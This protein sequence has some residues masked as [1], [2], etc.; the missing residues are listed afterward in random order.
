MSVVAT[1]PPGRKAAWC[2]RETRDAASS[3]TAS[4]LADRRLGVV[5]RHE[6]AVVVAGSSAQCPGRVGEV[7]APAQVDAG[8]EIGAAAGVDASGQVDRPAEFR[9][10][11]VGTVRIG[12]RGG[13]DGR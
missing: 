1:S 2:A 10:L 12:G 13:D 11:G 4:R 9:R 8:A 6:V 7:G 5:V 3:A